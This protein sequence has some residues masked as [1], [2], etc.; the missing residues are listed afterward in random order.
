MKVSLLVV[1]FMGLGVCIGYSQISISDTSFPIIGDSIYVSS[2]SSFDSTSGIQTGL[3]QTW[4]FQQISQNSSIGYYYRDPAT[5]NNHAAFSSANLMM[6]T[7]QNPM[8]ENYL[9]SNPTS[10]QFLGMAGNFGPFPVN[11]K[12]NPSVPEVFVPTGLGDKHITASQA[13]NS[14]PSS[15]L[16]DSILNQLPIKPD[17]FRITIAWADTISMSGSGI[18]KLPEESYPVVQFNH[19]FRTTTTLEMYIPFLGWQ[20]ITS[21]FPGSENL[22]TAGHEFIY[23]SPEVRGFVA[24]VGKQRP[25]ARYRLEYR[26]NWKLNNKLKTAPI[27]TVA[28]ISPVPADKILNISFSDQMITYN[29]QILDIQGKVMWKGNIS[30]DQIIEVGSWVKGLYLIQ[31]EN[32][33]G[34]RFTG[35]VLKL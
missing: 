26:T 4:D 21:L 24:K 18:L 34:V 9:F 28:Q 8:S 27:E 23:W 32:L 11:L 30:G 20:D 13:R 2:T 16:P 15:I 19:G 25:N 5:G 6:T 1:L 12:Y 33:D 35:R 14:F 29:V 10:L 17:S 31:A 22:N 3:N 7:S